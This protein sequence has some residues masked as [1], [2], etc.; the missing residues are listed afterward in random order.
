[1][2]GMIA[3]KIGAMRSTL[4]ATPMFGASPL[5]FKLHQVHQPKKVMIVS[6]LDKLFI[7]RII[8]KNDATCKL[9]LLQTHLL[10]YATLFSK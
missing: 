6:K 1:M 2:L 3:S 5:F 8:E 4:R 7:P 10:F 9:T